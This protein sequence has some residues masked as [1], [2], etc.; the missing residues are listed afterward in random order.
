[1]R[2]PKGFPFHFFNL[3]DLLFF[4]I[5][6]VLYIHIILLLHYY[7]FYPLF[8]IMLHRKRRESQGRFSEAQ[9]RHRD[10]SLVSTRSEAQGRFSCFR[11]RGGSLVSTRSVGTVLLFLPEAECARGTFRM[12]HRG[13]PY[14]A[15]QGDVSYGA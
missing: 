10:G 7:S 4:H 2:N 5:M 13:V 8:I 3:R 11:H 1:M 6:V 9:V 12:A 15:C 14:G